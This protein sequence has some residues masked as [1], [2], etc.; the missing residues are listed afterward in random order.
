MEF[1]FTS[2]SVSDEAIMPTNDTMPKMVNT[3]PAKTT[4]NM[5]AKVN[6]KKSF[7]NVQFY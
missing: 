6:L 3:M 7:M 5:L 1:S 2:V 4:P